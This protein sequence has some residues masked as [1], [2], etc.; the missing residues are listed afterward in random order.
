VHSSSSPTKAYSKS[1]SLSLRGSRNAAASAG[2]S[3]Q[4][5]DGQR[6]AGHA[7]FWAGYEQQQGRSGSPAAGVTAEASWGTVS[8]SSTPG[9]QQQQ[10]RGSRSSAGQQ[11]SAGKAGLAGGGSPAKRVVGQG[12]RAAED[13]SGY[14]AS[15][16]GAGAAGSGGGASRGGAGGGGS[17]TKVGRAGKL[18]LRKP[19]SHY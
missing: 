17:P 15:G 9:Q 10:L 1:Q 16:Y 19:A 5:A 12:S 6:A 14:H 11:Y 2:A 8:R 13:Y 7:G 4:A 3:P 18:S